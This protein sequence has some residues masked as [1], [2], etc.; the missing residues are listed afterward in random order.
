MDMQT[1]AALVGTVAKRLRWLLIVM[2]FVAF[3]DRTNISF[4]AAYM[5]HD[6]G[7]S[8]KQFGLGASLFF[9]GYL[10][11]EVP[12]N[13]VMVRAG[14]RRWLAR[15]MITWG[16]VS[17]GSAFVSG[18]TGFYLA[19]FLLGVAEAGFIPGVM[20]YLSYWS[21]QRYLGKFTGWFMMVI[22][23]SASITALITA[24]LLALDQVAGLAG[25]R[26]AFLLEGMPAILIGCFLLRYLSD[27]PA[28]A[29]W[30]TD[31]QKSQLHGLIEADRVE[32]HSAS[33][34]ML[35]QA[36]TTPLV[37]VFGVAYFFLNFALGAQ[38]WFPL[39]AHPFHLSRVHE[40]ALVAI[41]SA[42]ASLA[43]LL[44]AR[45]SDRANERTWHVIIPC[46]VSALAWYGAAHM[47]NDV[48][49]LTGLM[50]IA[51]SAMY[52]ALVVFWTMPTSFLSKTARPAGL[53]IITAL[54]LPGS[55]LSLS[56]GGQL[57]DSY[58]SFSPCFMLA[59]AGMLLCGLVIATL[60]SAQVRKSM[61]SMA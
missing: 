25:W 22:P 59:A 16:I 55:M 32:R 26:W 36:L 2:M 43:M 17:S 56:F 21:P 3:M 51:Y 54:G 20:L 27:T 42:L 60:C 53:A 33:G 40:T 12:S 58:G 37:W 13:L 41:P 31:A 45:H 30:L 18:P 7:L 47:V 8:T 11:F 52:A 38:T 23:I 29:A 24:S 10:L 44:W 50:S 35:R 1:D 19:R 34:G 57:R 9:L 14:A 28:T 46:I 48:S 5:N 15:I 61:R 39:A 6:I 49:A 4:V